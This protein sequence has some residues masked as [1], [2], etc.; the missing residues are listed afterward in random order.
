MAYSNV[1]HPIS[2]R[3]KYRKEGNPIQARDISGEMQPLRRKVSPKT[4][5]VRKV[6]FCTTILKDVGNKNVCWLKEE[7]AL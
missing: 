2:N 6:K 1:H 7:V 3:S 4:H 5:N